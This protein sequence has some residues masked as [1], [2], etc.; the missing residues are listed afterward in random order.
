MSEP[1]LELEKQFLP[2]LEN[3]K[4]HL[5][6]HHTS[7]FNS[8]YGTWEFERTYRCLLNPIPRTI[9]TFYLINF[10]NSKIPMLTCLFYHKKSTEVVVNVMPFTDFNE[11][12]TVVDL[13]NYSLENVI[14][15]MSTYYINDMHRKSK[16][17]F[18]EQKY[19]EDKLNIFR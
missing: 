5:N 9:Y 15:H 18:E 3:F 10:D 7:N 16:N 4:N 12:G 14:E 11:N 6:L 13:T 1:V 8:Y 17:F 2:F 19:Y